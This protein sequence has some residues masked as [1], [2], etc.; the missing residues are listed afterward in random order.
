MFPM[1]A[2]IISEGLQTERAAEEQ[3]AVEVVRAIGLPNFA[4][5]DEERCKVVNRLQR[6]R[7]LPCE[8][9][10]PFL[11]YISGTTITDSRG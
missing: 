10:H 1:G 4:A 11:T 6:N 2:H 8:M 7:Q 9:G 3:V 5:H